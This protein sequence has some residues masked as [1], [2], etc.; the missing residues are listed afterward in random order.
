[1]VSMVKSP[2]ELTTGSFEQEVLKSSTL[3][4]VDFWA[5][6]CGPCRVMGYVLED[7]LQEVGEEVTIAKLNVDA[8]PEVAAR[9]GIQSIPTILIF[10]DGHVMD[11]I[12]GAVPKKILAQRLAALTQPS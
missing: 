3:V 6:W 1:M 2:L 8:H 10:K 5:E 12:V 11:R 4:M 7:F 9:Y